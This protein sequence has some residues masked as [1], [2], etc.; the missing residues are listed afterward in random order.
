MM[1]ASQ[2][3]AKTSVEDVMRDTVDKLARSIMTNLGQAVGRGASQGGAK[4]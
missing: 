2:N 1:T 4:I 3:M